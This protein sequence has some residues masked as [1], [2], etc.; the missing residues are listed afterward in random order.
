VRL[1]C[2]DWEQ[3]SHAGELIHAVERGLKR[4][5]VLSYTRRSERN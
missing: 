3:A 4:D 2:D 1:F 5:D